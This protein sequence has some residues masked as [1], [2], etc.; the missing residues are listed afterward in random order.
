MKDEPEPQ[1]QEDRKEDEFEWI[2]LVTPE[3]LVVRLRNPWR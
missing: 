3:G 2:E 1:V